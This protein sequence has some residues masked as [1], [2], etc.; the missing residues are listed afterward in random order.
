MCV[1]V[2]VCGVCGVGV[3]W[4]WVCARTCG[5]FVRLRVLAT[6]VGAKQDA[7]GRGEKSVGYII[8]ETNYHLT[9]YTG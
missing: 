8:L 6:P 2:G 4:V 1:G 5:V 7:D 9:A 3:V